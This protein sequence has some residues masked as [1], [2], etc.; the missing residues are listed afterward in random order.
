MF[1]MADVLKRNNKCRTD[2]DQ[3]LQDLM[4]Q[5]FESMDKLQEAHPLWYKDDCLIVCHIGV[6]QCLCKTSGAADILY[7]VRKYPRSNCVLYV[8]VWNG[9]TLMEHP[10]IVNCKLF[11]RDTLSLFLTPVQRNFATQHYFFSPC[12][13]SCRQ[14]LFQLD[15]TV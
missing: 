14:P 2:R 9:L 8:T 15:Q 10:T 11:R 1:S 4:T 7:Y 13:V 12:V 5:L 3:A 6:L